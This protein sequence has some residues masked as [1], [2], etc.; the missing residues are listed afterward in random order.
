MFKA[1]KVE[2]SSKKVTQTMGGSWLSSLQE[3]SCRFQWTFCARARPVEDSTQDV[4]E[5]GSDKAGLTT[6]ALG[7][8][9]PMLLREQT[10]WI[11]MIC[12][13]ALLIS[14]PLIYSWH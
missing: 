7:M 12:G 14:D 3:S 6:F 8:E 9:W 2:G 13:E 4:W 10:W 5:T 1:C 11:G